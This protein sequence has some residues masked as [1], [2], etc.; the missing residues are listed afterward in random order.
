MFIREKGVILNVANIEFVRDRDDGSVEV[1][2]VSGRPF[3]FRD[4]RLKR[5]L[6]QVGRCRLVRLVR[7]VLGLR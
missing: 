7:S 5:K 1:V 6:L 3:V 2:M 4:D